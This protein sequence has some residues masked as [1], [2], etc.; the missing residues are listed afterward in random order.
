[1]DCVLSDQRGQIAQ[2]AGEYPL[3]GGRALLDQGG[4][5]VR[6]TTMADQLFA[7]NRQ[8]HQPHVKHQG[9]RRGDQIA[10]W[11]VAGAV[12][13]VTGDESHRLRVVTM[14][15]R[16]T[17][18]RRTPAGG[19]NARHHLKRNPVGGQFFDFLPRDQR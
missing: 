12:F 18:I 7:D 17:G 10:P 1:M 11:Q 15:Q 14:G 3:I 4:R 6:R 9:L 19:R 5:G 8:P 13:E 16:N 2:R